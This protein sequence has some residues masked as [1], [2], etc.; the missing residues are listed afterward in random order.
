MSKLNRGVLDRG[1]IVDFLTSHG[2]DALTEM[3]TTRAVEHLREEETAIIICLML[4]DTPYYRTLRKLG[5]TH[6]HGP[7]LNVRI[8]DQ[9][10]SKEFVT[11]PSNWYYVAGDDD[12]I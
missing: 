10:I 7:R 11:N 9:N 8:F 4:R 2:E 3:L 1:Y 5:F 12:S 6:R